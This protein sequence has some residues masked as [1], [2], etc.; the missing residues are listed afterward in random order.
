M[1]TTQQ[2]KRSNNFKGR[3]EAQMHTDELVADSRANLTPSQFVQRKL[4]ALKVTDKDYRR[5]TMGNRYGN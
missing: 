2:I 4:E 1:P 5:P 3:E